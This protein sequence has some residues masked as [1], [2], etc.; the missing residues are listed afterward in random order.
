M[1]IGIHIWEFHLH[2]EHIP[3]QKPAPNLWGTCGQPEPLYHMRSRL[4]RRSFCKHEFTCCAPFIFSLT[5]PWGPVLQPNGVFQFICLLWPPACRT[6]SRDF[7][8]YA[9]RTLWDSQ[10][11]TPASPRQ[12]PRCL[13]RMEKPTK[14]SI[15]CARK[16]NVSL[17]MLFIW[18]GLP[19]P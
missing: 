2:T 19:L 13:P 10:V 11:V 9:Y 17:I 16:H 6:V 1:L 12:D 18:F 7:S 5:A 15:I 14:Y 4:G 3:V 8:Y